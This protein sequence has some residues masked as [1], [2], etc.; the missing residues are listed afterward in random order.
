MEA[1][2]LSA[3]GFIDLYYALAG[4]PPVSAPPRMTE[5]PSIEPTA[6]G[7][8][9]FNTNTHQ[10]FESFLVMIG[11]TD[12]LEHDAAWASAPTRYERT[13]QWNKIVRDWTT[14]RTTAEI[15]EVASALR[16]PVAQV[17]NGRTV[18]DHPH[19]NARGVWAASADGSFTHPLR[20]TGSMARGPAESRRLRHGSVSSIRQLFSRSRDSPGTSVSAANLPLAGI[21]II[22]ATAWW[23][24]P[25]STHI[26]AALGAEVIHLESVQ[27][28]DGARM[29]AGAFMDQPSWWERSAMYLATNANKKGL[30]LDLSSPQRP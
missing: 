5:L 24:G 6:D 9:G 15:V 22:D 13:E 26:L 4:S 7:W 21:R 25:S 23:A 8:V 18:L 29:T 12:L 2:H 27:H 1:C 3:S 11:R 19:F 30:T 10:Q 20:P 14:Q 17:N 16:I 28:P